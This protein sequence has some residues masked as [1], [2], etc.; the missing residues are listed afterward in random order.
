MLNAQ[1][2]RVGGRRSVPMVSGIEI[3]IERMSAIEIEIVGVG[4]CARLRHPRFHTRVRGISLPARPQARTAGHGWLT[5]FPRGACVSRPKPRP[6]P[7]ETGTSNRT[8]GLVA[9]PAS[10]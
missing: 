5:R 4:V 10:V 8:D 3:G 7:P 9:Q 6:H 2:F 1:W